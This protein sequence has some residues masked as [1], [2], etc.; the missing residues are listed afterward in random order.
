MTY[1][2]VSVQVWPLNRG[3]RLIQRELA[4]DTGKN[5]SVCMSEK[6]GL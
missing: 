6:S 3:G 4:P 1:G 2:L 5:Y